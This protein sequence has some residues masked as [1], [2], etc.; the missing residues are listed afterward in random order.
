VS[1][2]KVGEGD[3]SSQEL[4][5]QHQTVQPCVFYLHNEPYKQQLS[6]T[7]QLHLNVHYAFAQYGSQQQVQYNLLLLI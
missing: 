3:Q 5:S 6:P 2:I 4:C 7:S 1:T